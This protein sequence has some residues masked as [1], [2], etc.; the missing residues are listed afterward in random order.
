MAIEK[1]KIVQFMKDYIELSEKIKKLEDEQYYMREL[2]RNYL[3]FNSLTRLEEDNSIA[4]LTSMK[5]E[6][7]DKNK[8][9]NI[10]SSEQYNEIL[11]VKDVETLKIMN[12][13]TY[14]RCKWHGKKI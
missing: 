8:A 5:R 10:L 4:I 14:E 9:R 13:D 3:K 12:K 11:S 1:S 7:L 6:T 2:V